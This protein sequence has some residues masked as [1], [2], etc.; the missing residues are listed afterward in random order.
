MR[1]YTR[2][3]ATALVCFLIV[4]V[5][6]FLL[7]RLLPGDPVAYLTGMAEED[8][9]STQYEYY[10]TA[11]HLDKSILVQFSY[12]LGSLL[13]GTLG[14]SYKK[15]AVVSA[16]ILERIGPTLQVT[17]SAV[18]LSTG[19]GL[20]WGLRCGLQKDGL[21]DKVSTSA[22]LVFN[23]VPTFL[24]GLVFIILL[25]FEHRWFP[26]SG[27]NSGDYPPG[28]W[29][30]FLDRLHHLALPVLTLTAAELPSRYLLMR[31]TARK[32]ADEKYILYA[33]ERGLSERTIQ[34]RYVL[35][36]IA[37]PFITMVGMSVGACV[38][39]SL[40]VENVFSLNGMGKLLSG[41]VNTLDYPLMQGI[42]FVTT[43]IMA[44]SIVASDVLCI[45]ID[46]RVR[47]GERHAD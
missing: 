4:V 2:S 31:N 35:K 20:F 21:L 30:Y 18:M 41:A 33:R 24:I 39:G 8:M 15:E 25:C 28:T 13:D 7:P 19:L 47:W 46:P 16:L 27:L 42:L 44:V 32:I 29:A 26:Y 34:S 43:A 6:N 1:R 11:L 14:Y 40:V 9:T 3:M 23:A 45:L 12:Y 22:L 10:Y 5:L 37:H 17:L 38:G 36:N